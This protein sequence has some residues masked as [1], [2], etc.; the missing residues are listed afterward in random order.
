MDGVDSAFDILGEGFTRNRNTNTIHDSWIRV[1]V[2]FSTGF[3]KFSCIHAKEDKNRPK[4]R[5]LEHH[6]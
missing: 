3:D 6:K 1:G 2:Y 4:K 5:I